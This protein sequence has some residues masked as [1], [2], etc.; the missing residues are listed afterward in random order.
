MIDESDKSPLA[1]LSV[2]IFSL[3]IYNILTFHDTYTETVNASLPTQNTVTESTP[4]PL[5]GE[6]QQQ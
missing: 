3:L 6:G 4:L 5:A 1:V 2:I